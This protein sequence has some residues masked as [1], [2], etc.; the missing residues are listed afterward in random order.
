MN[1]VR[2]GNIVEDIVSGLYGTACAILE[3]M[4]GMKQIGIQP[5]GD[6]NSI[7]DSTFIDEY[8]VEWREDGIADRVPKVVET[9]FEFGQEVRDIASG[10]VGVITNKI[11]YLNGCIHFGITTD[12]QEN[13]NPEVF[14]IDSRR[15]ELVSNGVKEKLAPKEAEPT[16]GPMTRMASVKAR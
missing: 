10:Q 6:G 7:P 11:T 14:Y 9:P 1:P 8:L 2:L 5:K 3:P 15:V 16:G 12:S 4:T 13:K